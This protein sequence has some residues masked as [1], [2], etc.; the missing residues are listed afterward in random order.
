MESSSVPERSQSAM[1][2]FPRQSVTCTASSETETRRLRGATTTLSKVQFSLFW[3]RNPMPAAWWRVTFRMLICSNFPIVQIAQPL[4]IIFG[5]FA[6]DTVYPPC[7]TVYRVKEMHQ[8]PLPESKGV[9][10][11]RASLTR[12][13][14][15][16][17]HQHSLGSVLKLL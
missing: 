14:R 9:R 4:C 7:Y 17:L 15:L 12:A 11:S 16:S 3:I 6:D 2:I 10:P 5:Y 8:A 1:R 13:Y